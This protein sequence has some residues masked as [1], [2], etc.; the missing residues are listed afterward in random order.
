MMTGQPVQETDRRFFIT[1]IDRC[2][3]TLSLTK[4]FHFRNIKQLFG[5]KKRPLHVLSRFPEN[6]IE[7]LFVLCFQ[8]PR[9]MFLL[10]FSFYNAK[11]YESAA[12]RW[13]LISFRRRV[14][15]YC[16]LVSFCKF[17]E[18]RFLYESSNKQN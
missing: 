2:Y 18:K 3:N 14:K 15:Q 16:I 7:F 12:L 1:Y 10:L 17:Y 6:V 11:S 13:M 4:T 9:R 8:S 5:T